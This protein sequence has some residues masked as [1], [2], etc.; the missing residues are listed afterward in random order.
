MNDG[1]TTVV[2]LVSDTNPGGTATSNS[3]LVESIDRRRFQVVVVA[4]GPGP[5]AEQVGCH[6]DEYHNLDIGSFP[7]IRKVREASVREDP[8]GWLA[9]VVWVLKCVWALRKWLKGRK[10]DIIHA[11]SLHFDLIGGIA[12]KLAGVPCLW[13]IRAPQTLA[14]RRGGPFLVE[15]YLAAYLATRFIANSHHTASGFHKSWQKKA[16][17]VWNAI[18]VAAV[19]ANQCGGGLRVRAGV[20][21]GEKVVGVTGWVAHGKGMDRF[22]EMAAKLCVLRDDVR[23][24]IVGGAYDNV[25]RRVLDALIGMCETLGITEK[26]SFVGNVSNASHYLCDMDVFFMCSRPGTETFGLVVIEAMAAGVPVVAFANNAMPEIIEDG[27]TGF[28][29]PEGDVEMAAERISQVLSDRVLSDR[30]V[31]S[32]KTTVREKFD[33][34]VL[35]RN[36]EQIYDDVL[37]GKST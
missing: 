19:E 27:R 36:V 3:L 29:V 15:G 6:A 37:Q 30:L 35:I 16:V 13:H 24:I 5:T 31:R 4:C 18:D 11:N 14:W 9:L 1:R 17:V 10:V 33:I 22:L 8:R 7:R 28:L 12:G 26:V 2:F 32:A 21:E 20:T 25:A 23:F 34:P